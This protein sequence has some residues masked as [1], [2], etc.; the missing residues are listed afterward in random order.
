M[1]R[2]NFIS[3]HRTVLNGCDQYT[4]VSRK[5]AWDGGIHSSNIYNIKT[6]QGVTDF[7]RH[8]PFLVETLEKL[9][10]LGKKHLTYFDWVG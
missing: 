8:Y 7:Y 9:V 6:P 1:K 4:L 5:K 2:K 10:R 3:V